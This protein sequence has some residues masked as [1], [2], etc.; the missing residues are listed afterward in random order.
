[1][2]SIKMTFGTRIGGS[3][4]TGL[5]DAGD[6]GLDKK[7]KKKVS[8]LRTTGM[9]GGLSAGSDF[10][11]LVFNLLYPEKETKAWT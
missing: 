9:K 1:M 4:A 6:Q 11:F 7:H 2:P 10:F 5:H 8:V 3:G